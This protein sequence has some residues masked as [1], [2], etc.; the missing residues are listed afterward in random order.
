MYMYMYV[1]SLTGLHNLIIFLQ[2]CPLPGGYLKTNIPKREPNYVNLHPNT[3][4][5]NHPDVA[6]PVINAPHP[7]RSDSSRFFDQQSP[8]LTEQLD[9]DYHLFPSNGHFSGLSS[10]MSSASTSSQPGSVPFDPN[11]KC[12]GCGKQFR[13]FEI[14]EFRRHASTCEKLRSQLHR[15]S[16]EAD[17]TAYREDFRTEEQKFDPNLTCIG[18]GQGFKE[19][20][21]QEFRKHCGSCPM[22]KEKIRL[23]SGSEPNTTRREMGSGEENARSQSVCGNA[24]RHT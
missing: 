20:Q 15:A 1:C 6:T 17:E 19:T 10:N 7:P 4:P 3:S 9:T 22:F 13:E 16:P 11:L 12:R 24:S 23:R 21:I 8:G 18:C 5:R 14:Q 2:V